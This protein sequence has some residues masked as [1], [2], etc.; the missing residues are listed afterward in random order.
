MIID[1]YKKLV[2]EMSYSLDGSQLQKSKIAALLFARPNNFTRQ[3]LFSDL[4]YFH[5]RSGTNINLYCL[6]YQPAL[7]EELPVIAERDDEKWSFNAQ[8]FD[9][10]RRRI[11]GET[12]WKYT[13]NAEL[14]LFNA[15][16]DQQSK[17]AFMD[18]SDA[19]A[20]DL[21][22]AKENKLIY[23]VSELFETIFRSSENLF[24][25]NP[26]KELSGSLIRSSGKTSLT[27]MLFNLLPEKVR[28]ETK[29]IY[30]FGTSDFRYLN[31]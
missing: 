10:L 27:T 7:L 22:S 2:E 25:E 21:Q 14:V 13:G 16:Y 31:S 26:S 8:K 17:K 20:I 11:E 19:I 3:E 4:D 28:T 1:S 30:L 18:F 12:R 29:R 6:G 9:N 24:T 23:S 15:V 5:F